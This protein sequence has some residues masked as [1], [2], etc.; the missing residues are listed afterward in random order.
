[1]TSQGANSYWVGATRATPNSGWSWIESSP[2]VFTNW[3]V[4]GYDSTRRCVTLVKQLNS[5]WTT[6]EC[7]SAQNDIKH[8]YICKKR[9]GG[10]S[11]TTTPVATTQQ[12]GV[13]YGC[14]AFWEPFEGACYSYSNE[15]GRQKTFDEARAACRQDRAEL[16]EVMS[17]RENEFL[18]T[19]LRSSPLLRR[20]GC[21]SGWTSA[22]AASCLKF[23]PNLAKANWSE[24]QYFCRMSGGY[25]ASVKSESEQATLTSLIQSGLLHLKRAHIHKYRLNNKSSFQVPINPKTIFGLALLRELDRIFGNLPTTQL[26][27]V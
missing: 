23:F 11:S 22:G 5:K 14:E 7:N 18:V 10:D 21:P 24:A 9:G 2:F 6:I 4:G 12:P 17:E 1:M 13:N 15:L 3:A 16:V 27:A 25:L 8:N 19:L 26:L 20:L